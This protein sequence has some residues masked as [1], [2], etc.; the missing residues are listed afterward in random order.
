MLHGR[1]VLTLSRVVEAA[2]RGPLPHIR[3]LS[4]SLR[5]FYEKHNK[6]RIGSVRALLESYDD[7]QLLQKLHD[8]Y[9]TTPIGKLRREL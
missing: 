4:E 6:K 3:G 8:Q 1:S 9:G 2:P 5:K 7:E